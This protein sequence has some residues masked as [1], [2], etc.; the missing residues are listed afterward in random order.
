MNDTFFVSVLSMVLSGLSAFLI[1]M[2]KSQTTNLVVSCL[3][4]AAS[5]MGFN[6]LDCLMAELFPTGLRLENKKTLLGKVD[7]SG[8]K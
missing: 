3:F 8:S 7:E 1:Y 2:V 4:G 5:T 6:A